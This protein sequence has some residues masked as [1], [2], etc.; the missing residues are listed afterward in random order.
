MCKSIKHDMN[1]NIYFSVL[2]NKHCGK[3]TAF[4]TRNHRLP[5]E[6]G[7]WNNTP[8]HEII[9]QLCKQGLGDEYHYIME[10]NYLKKIRKTRIHNYYLR[11]PNI[12]RF[13]E[14]FN[15]SN[16]SQLTKLSQF[17]EII[18]KTFRQQ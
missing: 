17:A 10:C 9:C 14:L 16:K 12:L 8:I 11:H 4:R 5:I 3:L 15:T 2:S 1:I 6:G 13:S 18:M 7:R